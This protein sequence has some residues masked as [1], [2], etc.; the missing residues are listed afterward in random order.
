MQVLDFTLG[1]LSLAQTLV[2][3][4]ACSIA[5]TGDSIHALVAQSGQAQ[6]ATLTY[7]AGLWASGTPVGGL[8]GIVAVAPIGASGAVAAVSGGLQYLNLT[9]GVWASGAT[10]PLSF[11]PVVLGLDAFNQVYAAGNGGIAMASG[12]TLVASG[13]YTGSGVPSAI[14]VQQG[15]IILRVSGDGQLRTF[16]YTASGTLAQQTTTAI[17]LGFPV[18]LALSTTTLFAMGSGGTM[19]FGFSGSPYV[20]TPVQSGLVGFWGGASWT[21]AGMG[22]GHLPAAI[23]LDASGGA[24]V[25]TKQNTLWHIAS[26][27]SVLTSGALQQYSGQT[28][29]VPLCPSA[30]IVAS[31]A[32]YVATSIPGVLEQVA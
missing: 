15:R 16:G 22:I 6:A 17:S 30:L 32:A 26:G 21:T 31:G 25:A 1:V 5:V 20:L 13:T 23:G 29:T 18:G 28:Q 14:A 24:W 4:G 11:M 3:S 19:T 2:L 7:S 27:G 10:V 9:A 12:S 8:G